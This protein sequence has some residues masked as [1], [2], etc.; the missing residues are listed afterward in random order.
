MTLMTV[1]LAQ[2]AALAAAAL[3]S[4]ISLGQAQQ[5]PDHEIHFICPFVPGSGAD[6]LVRY[7][8]EKIRPLAGKP[9]L[10]ENRTGAGS[11][12][13]IE[14]TA[15]SKPDGYTMLISGSG[16]VASSMSLF[17]K[18]PV[19]VG[20]ALQFAGTTHRLAFMVT[21][22]SNSPYHT[23]AELTAAMKEKGEKA[24]YAT[25]NQNGTILGELYKAH[26][27]IKAVEV[28]Y[29]NPASSLND[30]TSGAVD[31]GVFDPG[32]S[33]A[34]QRAGRLRILGVSSSQRFESL[35]DIPTMAEQG[36]PIDLVSWWGAMVPAGTPRP[37][38][39]QISAWF[40]QVAKTDET[41]VFLA[42]SGAEP[43]TTSIDNA[44]QMF[45]QDIETWR[46]YVRIAKIQ[47]EG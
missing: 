44:Q 5:Y 47:P 38:I 41:R 32:Y 12:I 37:I 31:F 42:G 21:V 9:V 34:Q 28:K 39:D 17:K 19:D 24:T 30:Q 27:G 7:F 15:R 43:F 33:L 3:L 35:P 4:S 29:K 13:A 40:E 16:G 26:T 23:L 22:A 20:S 45:R 36:V 14:Y 18:P 10:V 25:G 1:R 8:A 11:N 6:V 2:V 46:D